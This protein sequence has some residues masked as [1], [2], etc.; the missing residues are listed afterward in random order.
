MASDLQKDCV[1]KSPSAACASPSWAPLPW[2]AVLHQMVAIVAVRE[3]KP[4]DEVARMYFL[5]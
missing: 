2:Y 1:S 5:T 3:T 4:D